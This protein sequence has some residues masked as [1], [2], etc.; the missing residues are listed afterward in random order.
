MW[1]SSWLVADCLARLLTLIFL[2]ISNSTLTFLVFSVTQRQICCCFCPISLSHC[3]AI[4]GVLPRY[5]HLTSSEG[6]EYAPT[7]LDKGKLHCNSILLLKCKYLMTSRES[8]SCSDLQTRLKCQGLR[9]KSAM[10]WTPDH[11]V[12]AQSELYGNVAAP[13]S[14]LLAL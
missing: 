4:G 8:F 5:T 10:N 6:T 12:E 2:M 13:L 1:T 7:C 9:W 11:E 3:W 14:V